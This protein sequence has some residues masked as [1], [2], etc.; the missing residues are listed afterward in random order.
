MS[1][2]RN[3]PNNMAT[4]SGVST[5]TQPNIS[6]SNTMVNIFSKGAVQNPSNQSINTGTSSSNPFQN[7]QSPSTSAPVMI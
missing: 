4:E 2:V 7:K 5:N 6:S 1:N 3:Q